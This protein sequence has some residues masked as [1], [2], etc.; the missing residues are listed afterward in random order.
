M[1][2]ALPWMEEQDCIAG[3]AWFPFDINCPVGNSSALFDKNGN[4]TACGRYYK[5]VTPENPSGDQT[6]QPDPPHHK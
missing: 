6:I 4:L 1:K 5:S 3:Y 2:Q